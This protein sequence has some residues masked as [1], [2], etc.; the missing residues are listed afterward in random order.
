MWGLGLGFEGLGFWFWGL[1]VWGLL[2]VG[3]CYLRFG[4]CGVHACY[5]DVGFVIVVWIFVMAHVWNLHNHLTVKKCFQGVMR[6]GVWGLKYSLLHPAALRATK[7]LT[8]TP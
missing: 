6:F 1:R 5:L 3:V 2:F 7:P 4:V 8:P